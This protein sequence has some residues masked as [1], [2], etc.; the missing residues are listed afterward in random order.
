MLNPGNSPNA[1]IENIF[2]LILT[3]IIKIG[4]TAYTFGM[5]VNGY[6]TLVSP[7]LSHFKIDS[8]GDVLACDHHRE[9]PRSGGWFDCVS[10]IPT[11]IF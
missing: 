3:A 10:T 7:L 1:E 9:L 11:C 5:M 2:L 6:L 4:L 8:C